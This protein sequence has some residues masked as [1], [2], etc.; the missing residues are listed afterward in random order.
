MEQ[1]AIDVCFVRMCLIHTHCLEIPLSLS[2]EKRRKL[3]ARLLTRTLIKASS[4]FILS[5]YE[6]IQKCWNW[7]SPAHV[8]NACRQTPLNDINIQHI[9]CK[10]LIGGLSLFS[11][12]IIIFSVRTFRVSTVHVVF[13]NWVGNI[14]INFY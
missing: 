12:L 13:G 5:H 8:A 2:K 3:L 7:T 11:V 9:N 4:H 1:W 10:I 6:N 14:I